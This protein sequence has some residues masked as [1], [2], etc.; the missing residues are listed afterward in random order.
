MATPTTLR[1]LCFGDSLTKGFNRMSFNGHPYSTKLAE[2]IATILPEYNIA[3]TVSGA[4][5]DVVHG[6]TFV[7]RMNRAFSSNQQYDWTIV[8]GGTNDVA[9]TTG[10]AEDIFHDLEKVYDIP[11]SHGS[12]LLALTIP[13][14]ATADK[15][16]DELRE[17]VNSLITTHQ[18]E[19]FHVFDLDKAM[20]SRALSEADRELY[21]DD[22][23]HCTAAGYDLIGQRVGEALALLMTQ[24]P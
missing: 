24:G 4:L 14:T 10:T 2:T 20:P 7:R 17:K 15:G 3:A 5:G 6:G 23:T 21:W 22:G 1:V 9:N 8:L 19:N 13:E 18:A 11:L 16:R 12:K